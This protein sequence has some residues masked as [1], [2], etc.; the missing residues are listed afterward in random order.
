MQTQIQ[1]LKELVKHS[2]EVRSSLEKLKKRAKR[3]ASRSKE[4]ETLLRNTALLCAWADGNLAQYHIKQGNLNK[5]ALYF[6]SQGDYLLEGEDYYGA[7]GAWKSSYSR[8]KSRALQRSVL[9]K[10]R[11]LYIKL[12]S[13]GKNAEPASWVI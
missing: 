10:T 2:E 5:A 13:E 4:E 11:A 3:I 9:D 7:I 12:T 1:K 6:E 8:A